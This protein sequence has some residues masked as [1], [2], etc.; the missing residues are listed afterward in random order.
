MRKED[1]S[2]GL[3]SSS[4]PLQDDAKIEISD[5]EA[6]LNVWELI[7]SKTSCGARQDSAGGHT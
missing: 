6:D 7:Q 2:A 4:A 3:T 5:D 1:N